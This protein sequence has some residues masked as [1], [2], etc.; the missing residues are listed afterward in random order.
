LLDHL[1]ITEKVYTLIQT[2]PQ[3]NYITPGNELPENGIYIFFERGEHIDLGSKSVDRIVRIETHKSDSQF[4]GRIRQQYGN[5]TSLSL[6][7][8][9]DKVPDRGPVLA[10]EKAKTWFTKREDS[11]YG[12]YYS[13]ELVTEEFNNWIN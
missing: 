11:T 1:S 13:C 5:K 4:R 12:S 8:I 7:K 3:F 10:R 2:L 6:G 9:W